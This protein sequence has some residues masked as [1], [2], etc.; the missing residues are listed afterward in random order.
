MFGTSDPLAP[1]YRAAVL[2]AQQLGALYNAVARVLAYV[3]Q[4]KAFRAGRRAGQPQVPLA[5]PLEL[6]EQRVARLLQVVVEGC[7]RVEEVGHGSIM[8]TDPD[9]RR[10]VRATPPRTVSA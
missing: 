6:P 1:T 5:H 3:L 10:P 2:A 8:P 9:V 4:I 7:R